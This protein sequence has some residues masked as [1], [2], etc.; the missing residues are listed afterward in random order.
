[1]KGEGWALPFISS[2]PTAPTLFGY[3][4]LLSTLGNKI[5]WIRGEIASQEQFLPF[6]TIFSAYISD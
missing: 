3:G 5:L 2:N 6:S 4:K 1:M